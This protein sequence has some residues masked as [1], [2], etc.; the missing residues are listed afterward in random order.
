MRQPAASANCYVCT[1]VVES[2]M[3][4]YCNTCGN[5]YHL[6]SR[7]DLP[8][9]DCGQVWINEEHL[10][11]QFACNTCLTPPAPANIDDVV[12]LLEANLDRLAH[13]QEL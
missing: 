2:H 6:N 12:D 7:A 1:L 4:A 10:S 8:G 5:L 13:G 9:D 11:L 3:E